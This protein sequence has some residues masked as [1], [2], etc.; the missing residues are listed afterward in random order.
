VAIVAGDR[1]REVSSVGEVNVVNLD[2]GIQETSV[3]FVTGG[4]R[5]LGHLRKRDGPLRVTLDAG[6]LLPLMAFKTGLFG[7][8]IGGRDLRI[9][10]DIVMAPNAGIV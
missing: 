5:R 10:I 1:P 6:G 4:V 8:S 2:L 7:G 3:T 9:V